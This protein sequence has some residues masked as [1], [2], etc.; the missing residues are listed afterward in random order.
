MQGEV[1]GEKIEYIDKYSRLI[2]AA[3]TDEDTHETFRYYYLL[4]NG[5][6]TLINKTPIEKIIDVRFEMNF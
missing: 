5:E 2:I 1:I 3:G 6:L 4:E